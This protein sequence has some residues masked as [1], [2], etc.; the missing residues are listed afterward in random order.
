MATAVLPDKLI[1]ASYLFFL[2]SEAD[3]MLELK[4][5]IGGTFDPHVAEEVFKLD[6]EA[7][8]QV[9]TYLAKD[10]PLLRL[11]VERHRHDNVI[12]VI[13][14]NF[15]HSDDDPEWG[16]QID[17]LDA[18]AKTLEAS[19]IDVLGTTVVAVG[20]A[21]DSA[22]SFSTYREVVGEPLDHIFAKFSGNTIH[23][24]LGDL[25]RPLFFI[26]DF[27]GT[28]LENVVTDMLPGIVWSMQRLT[29]EMAF[30]EDRLKT[31][32]SEKKQIDED[33][34]KIFH[35][36]VGSALDAASAHALEEQ[37]TQ[38]SSMYSMMATDLHLVSDAVSTFDR[39]LATLRERAK[40]LGADDEDAFPH[41]RLAAFSA[42][43][44]ELR[45]N[46]ADLRLSLDNTKA[47][48]DIA[49]TQAEIL[50]GSQGL[51]LQ[52]QT[53]ELLDQNLILQDE[54]ASLQ[55]AASVVELVVIFYYSLV[56]WKTVAVYGTVEVLSPLAKFSVVGIFSTAVETLTH[57][58]GASLH[59]KKIKWVPI[60]VSGSFV[61]ATLVAMALL[62]GTVADKA[63]H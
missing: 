55:A 25:N 4:K 47:A 18:C 11:D 6:L 24:L 39:D 56:A 12:S 10:A 33:L 36:K 9:E 26:E 13:M 52:E 29:R 8:S 48:I 53:R 1:G 5:Y 19:G 62:P 2:E 31:I 15:I 32:Q 44:K 63:E 17:F 35:Q 21:N 60:L 43:L 40:E 58:I 22:E 14:A 30:F 49:Q 7:E 23:Q 51:A 27:G 41:Y 57:Y 3:P 59:S 28:N 54:R 34:S 45:K 38:L 46:Q 16:R 37:I 42:Y 50:R 61:L 20:D